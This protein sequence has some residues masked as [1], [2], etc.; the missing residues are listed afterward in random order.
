[1]K[2]I[3][4]A[5]VLAGALMTSCGPKSPI[6]KGDTTTLDTLSY[7]FGSDVANMMKFQARNIP[8]DFEAFTAGMTEAAFGKSK[9]TNAE[10]IEIL[11]DYFQ[12]KRGDRMRK[13]MKERKEQDS[14]R[15]AQGDTTKVEY[16]M[17]DP[18]MFESEEERNAVS[19]AYGRNI[20]FSLRE[21]ELPLQMYWVEKGFNEAF[22]ENPQVDQR[23]ASNF[24]RV[25]MTETL[26]AQNLKLSEEWLAS[27]EKKSGV[28]KT[29]SGLLYRIEKMG[30]TTVIA[31]NVRD[32]VK[33]H[34]KGTKRD[35]KVFDASRYKDMPKM[36]QEM[37][38]K[39]MPDTYDQDEPAEFPL[40]RVIKGW[41][42]GMQLV[43]KGG[44]ITLWIHPDLA[45]GARGNQ[46][47]R[48]NEA[49]C[50]EVELIDV[51]P[52]EGPRPTSPELKL[53]DP[54]QEKVEKK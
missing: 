46:A 52:F 22:E 44:K 1:M 43:G 48:G 20:G 7:A 39:Q 42:E 29:E 54:K 14:I 12:N 41:T 16:P 47:I 50:F 35:G 51:T 15:L 36:R 25:Y 40:N 30:D 9:M 31:K 21:M 27:I 28:K 4:C 18:A 37:L 26:P 38:K 19:T 45:Y 53:I 10:A 17:A 11:Q 13:I 24:L 33:V 8:L 32:K 3:L 2:K 34:Y 49:L 23:T 5:M 6:T